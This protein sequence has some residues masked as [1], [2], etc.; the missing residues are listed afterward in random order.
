MECS[1]KDNHFHTRHGAPVVAMQCDEERVDRQS[2][3][4]VEKADWLVKAGIDDVAGLWQRQQE[5]PPQSNGK[6]G[7]LGGLMLPL[8]HV[9]RWAHLPQVRR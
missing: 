7:S 5:E 2:M 4:C 3:A 6:G 1:K 8:D 9:S